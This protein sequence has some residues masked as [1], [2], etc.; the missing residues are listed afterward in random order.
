MGR[1]AVG[2]QRLQRQTDLVS[3]P[4]R[5]VLDP[6]ALRGRRRRSERHDGGERQAEQRNELSHDDPQFGVGDEP[7]FDVPRTSGPS[8]TPE[9]E[10]AWIAVQPRL[11]AALRRWGA[12]ADTAADVGQDVA[13]RAWRSGVL[14]DSPDDLL[15]WS[16]T[17]GRN[18]LTDQ[19]RRRARQ[20]EP[21]AAWATPSAEDE[22]IST[23]EVR[24]LVA[25][26][27]A[28]SDRDRRAILPSSAALDGAERVRRHRARAR[29]AKLIAAF[30][31]VPHGS[32]RWVRQPVA[33]A[34]VAPVT[35][36]ALAVW[37]RP[38]H[39]VRERGRGT[40]VSMVPRGGWAKPPSGVRAPALATDGQATPS[41]DAA[42]PPPN[43][44]WPR[45]RIDV[46]VP[47]GER[48]ALRTDEKAGHRP[49]FCMRNGPVV[50][51]WCTPL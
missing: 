15:R 41:R 36:A 51:T 23:L 17:V 39:E 1:G 31:A 44:P 34:V 40:V 19:R 26:F 50:G 37:M 4:R 38:P 7:R 43:L 49:V 32:L 12:D 3:G 24:R 29:F 10:T 48:P 18:L 46:P 20:P 45:Q 2:P 22:A 5:D 28:L 47:T 14:F 9:F 27:G 21:L 33:V 16:Y 25:S 35:I 8:V 30:A 11:E 6:D 42:P 13:E